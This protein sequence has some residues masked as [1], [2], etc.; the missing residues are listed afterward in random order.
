MGEAGESRV[1]LGCHTGELPAFWFEV[2]P[3]RT[4]AIEGVCLIPRFGGG[5]VGGGQKPESCCQ[6][7]LRYLCAHVNSST[8][9]V[10]AMRVYKNCS[11]RF[12]C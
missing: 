3:R 1:N 11:E 4:P 2:Y 12:D 9:H 5:G 6:W 8:G 7:D 10:T